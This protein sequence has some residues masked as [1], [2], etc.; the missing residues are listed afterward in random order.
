MVLLFELDSAGLH[1]K[2]SLSTVGNM[3][4][5][6]CMCVL[7]SGRHFRFISLAPHSPSRRKYDLLRTVQKYDLS[8][9]VRPPDLEAADLSKLGKPDSKDSEETK[10][11]RQY[12]RRL[13][14]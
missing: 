10:H 14:T 8:P 13:N 2:F 7:C 12:R 6:V 3:N 1:L 9:L 11:A 4:L 5:Y